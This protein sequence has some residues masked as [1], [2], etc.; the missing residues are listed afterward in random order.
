[1]D[2]SVIQLSAQTTEI[3]RRIEV[4][5]HQTE[6]PKFEA[7]MKA[8]G[9]YQPS[10]TAEMCESSIARCFLQKKVNPKLPLV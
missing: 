1:M 6:I 9:A 2:A 7:S 10:I 8:V 5:K 3:L 4:N